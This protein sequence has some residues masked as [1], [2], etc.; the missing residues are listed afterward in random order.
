MSS[1][2]EVVILAR[3]AGTRQFLADNYKLVA[4]QQ[5]LAVATEEASIAMKHASERSW[6]YN[7]ALFTLRRYVYYGTLAL[8][9]FGAA[10]LKMGFDFNNAMQTATVALKPFFANT[11]DLNHA[12]NRLWLIAKY[13]P[14]QIKDMTTAF[15]A[16]YPSFKEL[17]ISSDQ[18]IDTIQA[19]IDGLS[20]A[21]KVSGPALQRVTIAL[22]HMAFQGR[23]TG[24][25]VNQLAR[26]GIPIFAIL[27]KELGLTADQMHHVGQ[28]GIPASVAMQAIVQYMQ[29]TPGYAGAAMRQSQQT[30]TGL[31]STF[32]DN[33][34][35]MMGAIEKDFFGKIQGRTAAMDQWFNTFFQ[36]FQGRSYSLRAV[37]V[38][39]FGAN[40]GKLYDQV[41]K[42][43]NN[44]WNIFKNLVSDIAHSK[45]LW[46]TLFLGLVAL[47]KILPPI[48]FFLQQFGWLLNVLIPLLI[49]WKVTQIAVNTQLKWQLFWETAN[50][51]IVKDA[52]MAQILF[53]RNL[54]V[55]RTAAKLA[56]AAQIALT[57]AMTAFTVLTKGW[58]AA[59]AAGK[60]TEFEKAVLKLRW[61]IIAL[62]QLRF[63]DAARYMRQAWEL[64][65]PIIRRVSLALYEQ[66]IPAFIRTGI[67]AAAAWV[68]ALGP[69]AWII[70]AV[71]ALITILI[72]LYFRWKWFHN[73]V[74]ATLKFMWDHPI[75]LWFIPV[76]GWLVFMVR[77]L[78]YFKDQ[79]VAAWN[80]IEKKATGAWEAISKKARATWEIITEIAHMIVQAFAPLA[81]A[82]A[83]PFNYLWG[84]LR[85]MFDWIAG[86]FGWLG[87]KLG[88]LGGWLGHIPGAHF[89]GKYVLGLAEGGTLRQPGWTLVGERGPELLMLPGGASVLPLPTTSQDPHLRSQQGISQAAAAATSPRNV[90]KTG[91]QFGQEWNTDR[92]LVIQLI[93][94]RKVI[95]E[96]TVKN[97]Q[98]RT[99]RR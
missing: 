66:L 7:Q 17:G 81:G 52:T 56:T 82:L 70:A 58:G 34:S 51:K 3:L 62:L 33:L 87:H 76:V 71:V 95:E 11:E 85:N 25:S 42:A 27:R 79:F 23:L 9:G 93:L 32:K 19:L 60:M 65:L 36:H 13:T 89:F 53:N 80:W 57:A 39:A 41:T 18:T 90:F 12:L 45:A 6:L 21:G 84:L 37:L 83:T 46:A 64:F 54:I 2:Q 78:W 72:V 47:N 20:V 50:T 96:V 22:Q 63:A 55:Y 94:D 75:L 35:R 1:M 31:W 92:P 97:A 69:V 61:A 77:M 88:R 68:A 29:Q 48:N 74:N 44:F 98:A 10:A 28:L 59:G 49:L 8:T 91:S 15:R 24:M 26:D 73:A 43:L 4:G 67:A 30:L 99:A 40:A 38:Y 14:F 5:Q 16:L 86:K